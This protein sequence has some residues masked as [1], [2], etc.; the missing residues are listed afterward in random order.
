MFPRPALDRLEVKGRV[1]SMKKWTSILCL[2]ALLAGCGNDAAD[3][4]A[5][6]DLEKRLE[7]AES[8]LAVLEKRLEAQEA[9]AN[10]TKSVLRNELDDNLIAQAK[11]EGR[12]KKTEAIL[13]I[14]LD[15]LRRPAPATS[16][17]PVPPPL[18]KKTYELKKLITNLAGPV[19]SRFISV[20]LVMEGTVPDFLKIIEEHEPRLRH[21]ALDTLG[22]Y[23]YKDAQVNGFMER[24]NIDLR[25]RFDDVLQKH[26]QGTAE[27]ITK[28]YFKEFVIQ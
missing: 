23:E 15:E 8:G 3:G 9:E 12:L 25:K 13:E 4:E 27:L 2:A 5:S 14:I 22:S 18:E 1:G 21:A 6:K 10:A 7:N 11:L 17:T 16:S 28:L 19:K 26:R 20:D 24:A